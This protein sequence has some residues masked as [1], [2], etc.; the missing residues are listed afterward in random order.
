MYYS[1]FLDSS[2]GTVMRFTQSG[3]STFKVKHLIV[4]FQTGLCRR[5]CINVHKH[6]DISKHWLKFGLVN[7]NGCQR[8]TWWTNT[9]SGGSRGAPSLLLMDRKP[10][11]IRM[12]NHLQTPL[13][14]DRPAASSSPRAQPPAQGDRDTVWWRSEGP[15]G[16]ETSLSEDECG[17]CCCNRVQLMFIFIIDSSADY[18]P[19]STND[20]QNVCISKCLVWSD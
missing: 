11:P 15:S 6:V 5:A 20:L 18:F 2:G 16:P 4:S 9:S 8:L 7:V 19:E 13:P 17:N 12:L 10:K 3:W 1:Q 14:R